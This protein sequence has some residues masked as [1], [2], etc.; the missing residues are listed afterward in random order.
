[1]EEGFLGKPYLMDLK[2]R[3]GTF[4]SG[5]RLE[6]HRFYE[7]LAKDVIQF[8]TSSRKYVVLADDSIERDLEDPS[9][10]QSADTK[11]ERGKSE[12]AKE[13]YKIWSDDDE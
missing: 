6:S 4:L 8:G 3:H 5:E 11:E 10:I 13:Q 7:V 12:N 9:E 2:S 1:M